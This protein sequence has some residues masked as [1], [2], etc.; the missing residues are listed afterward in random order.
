[1]Q[2]EPSGDRLRRIRSY[3]DP[4]EGDMGTSSY[5]SLFSHLPL[6]A[7]RTFFDSLVTI[8]IEMT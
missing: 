6:F 3:K 7:H 4:E 8:T 1:M 5:L 2:E